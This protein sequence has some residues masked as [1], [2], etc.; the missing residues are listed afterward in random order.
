MYVNIYLL[1]YI[2]NMYMSIKFNHLNV[3]WLHTQN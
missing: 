2:Y 1:N 3:K